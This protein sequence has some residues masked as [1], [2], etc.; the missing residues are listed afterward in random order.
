MR[1][2]NKELCLIWLDSFIGLEYKHKFE[3]YKSIANV[4]GIKEFI[5]SQKDYMEK[6]IGENEYS[7][8]LASAN[9]DYL[10]FVL[11]GLTSREI[12]VIT[13]ESENYPSR[14]KELEYPPLVLYCKGDVSLLSH[15]STFGIVG[16]RRS[17][18][19]SIKLAESYTKALVKAGL[20][21]VTGIAEGIDAT[22]LK[23]T[24]S[25]SGKAISVIAGGFDN[26]Y[27]KSNV[28]LLESVLNGG[29]LVVAEYPP[30]TV[31][32]PFHFPVRNRIISALSNGVLVVSAGAKS[33]TTYTAEYAVELSKEVFAIPYSVGVQSGIG[34][35]ELIKK[36]AILTDNPDDILEFY[37]IEKK[38]K[39]EI[40]LSDIEKEIV[41]ALSDGELHIEKLASVMGVSVDKVTS[42]LPLLEIKGIVTKC[43]NAY[44]LC[45]NDL[46]V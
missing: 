13:I 42:V 12:T 22:V 32:K 2:T 21:T 38:D 24:V 3:L 5:A 34:C 17:L 18:P 9:P 14:L 11:K 33:G 19:L 31:P 39:K 4:N 40:E 10:D 29:G 28:G 37:G 43:G 44:V 46:E 41:I 23:T 6:Q 8:L 1:Y 45:R 20:V 30:Q 25:N 35:N 15:P 16:S 7:T 26:I 36:G 27:P